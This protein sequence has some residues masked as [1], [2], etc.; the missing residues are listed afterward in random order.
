MY[1][2]Y[3]Y[4]EYCTKCNCVA[5]YEECLY[6]LH[7]TVRLKKSRLIFVKLLEESFFPSWLLKMHMVCTALN[8]LMVSEFIIFS[9][10]WCLSQR[11][12]VKPFTHLYVFCRSAAKIPI[13][14]Y[15][16][17]LLLLKYCKMNTLNTTVPVLIEQ[18]PSYSLSHFLKKQHCQ[19]RLHAS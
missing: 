7:N 8:S 5:S 13:S 10:S 18:M 1:K 14:T 16:P 2:N 12:W 6:L 15:W 9:Y 11:V 3:K 19:N 4:T 17:H